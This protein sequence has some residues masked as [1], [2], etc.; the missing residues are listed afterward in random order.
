MESSTMGWTSEEKQ[1]DGILRLEADRLALEFEVT[2]STTNMGTGYSTDVESLGQQE[3]EIPFD[4]LVSLSLHL[5]WLLPKIRIQTN[6]LSAFEGLPGAK[7]GVVEL[8]I[9]RRHL[10]AARSLIAELEFTR[11]DLQ[12][13]SV[14]QLESSD[15]D[16]LPPV[17]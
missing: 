3:L 11:A 5:T 9:K 12:L 14:T 16:A 2:L 6:R 4:Q 15:P 13:R 17:D 1:V 7:R 10:A 8:R